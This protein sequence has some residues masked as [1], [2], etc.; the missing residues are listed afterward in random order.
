[1]IDIFFP[2]EKII[3]KIFNFAMKV[4]KNYNIESL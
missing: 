1:M 3:A 2:F 4:P